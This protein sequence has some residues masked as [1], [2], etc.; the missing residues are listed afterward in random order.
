MKPSKPLFMKTY[1]KQMRKISAW[2]S[3]ENRKQVFDSSFSTDGDIPVLET[4]NRLKRYV[5]V[6]QSLS[7][8]SSVQCIIVIYFKFFAALVLCISYYIFTMLFS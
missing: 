1:G 6:V 3:P 2:L 4:S 5:R 7:R 8:S